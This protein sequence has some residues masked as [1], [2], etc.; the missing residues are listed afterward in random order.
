MSCMI[1]PRISDLFEPIA[2]VISAQR[3]FEAEPLQM[4]RNLFDFIAPPAR[5]LKFEM[6]VISEEDL[7]RWDGL[8]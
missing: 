3:E 2:F 4:P 5:R 1:A 8:S 7:E 6:V